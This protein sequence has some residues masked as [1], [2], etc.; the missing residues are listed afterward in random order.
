[1]GHKLY[2][3]K[4]VGVLYVKRRQRLE[5]LLSGGGQEK[6]WRSGTHNVPAIVGLGT[7]CR[8]ARGRMSEDADRILPLRERLRERL[9]DRVPGVVVN[10]PLEGRLPGNLN[11]SFE[12]LDGQ[13]LI[14]AMRGISVSSGSACAAG[15]TDPSYVLTAMGASPE[16]AYGS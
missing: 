10:G 13:A 3:P 14:Q 7:A 8:L 11:V 16:R 15:S 1:S 2:G 12:E 6:G 4:G 5:P 9:L